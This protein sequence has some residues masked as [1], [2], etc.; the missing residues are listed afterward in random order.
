M[1]IK[2]TYNLQQ[3]WS[4]V[5]HLSCQSKKA[6]SCNKMKAGIRDLFKISG[7]DLFQVWLR[8][9]RRM[10]KPGMVTPFHTYLI[11]YKVK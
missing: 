11:L 8:R 6:D 7:C 2:T 5:R 4:C 3:R 1:A 9:D 10:T